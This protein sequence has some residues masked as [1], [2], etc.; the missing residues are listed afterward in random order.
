M[1]LPPE[2]PDILLSPELKN[3][4]LKAAK[5]GDSQAPDNAEDEVDFHYT[6]FVKA[7]GRLLELDGDLS[8][9]V[10]LG[11][12]ND[13][14]DVVSETALAPIKR[15]M[16]TNGGENICFS[17]LALVPDNNHPSGDSG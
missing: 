12:L 5:D 13:D 1:T 3:H 4:Y 10:D 14:E 15:F 6:C 17:M 2:R 9:P 11:E 8:G 7:N 16:Q